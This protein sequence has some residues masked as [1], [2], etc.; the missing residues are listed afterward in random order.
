MMGKKI[1]GVAFLFTA[2]M[3]FAT[4]ASESELSDSD[5]EEFCI[6]FTEEKIKNPIPELVKQIGEAE[7]LNVDI[8]QSFDKVVTDLKDRCDT[9]L[10][11]LGT[12]FVEHKSDW[13]SKLDLLKRCVDLFGRVSANYGTVKDEMTTVY[14]ELVAITNNG[15]FSKIQAALM[16]TN[17]KDKCLPILEETVHCIWQARELLEWM[18]ATKEAEVEVGLLP[19]LCYFATGGAY[20]LAILTASDEISFSENAKKASN[21]FWSVTDGYGYYDHAR[22]VNDEQHRAKIEELIEDEETQK[23]MMKPFN[24]T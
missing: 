5:E 23:I 8:K 11:E 22:A 1:F 6:D 17:Y 21:Y 12:E 10:V 7:L 2:A 19:Q 15:F 4:W 9:Q 20:V 13:N 14:D 3:S 24:L 16:Y 18:I